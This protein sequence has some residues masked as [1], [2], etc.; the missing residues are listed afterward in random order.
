MAIDFVTLL[1]AAPF[2]EKNRQ[3]LLANMDKL[4][5][6]QKLRLST[7]AWTALSQMYFAKLKYE[8]EK[9]MLEIQEGKRK[10]NKNDFDEIKKKV[11]TEF[12]KKLQSAETEE[13]IEGVRSKLKQFLKRPSPSTTV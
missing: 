5:D 2:P 11:S 8:Q 3:K 10:F 4:T 6:D 1:K 9:L 7:T 13:E 12:A